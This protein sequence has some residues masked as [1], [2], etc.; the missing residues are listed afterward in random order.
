MQNKSELCNTVY[1]SHAE[2]LL[3]PFINNKMFD[4]SDLFILINRKTMTEMPDTAMSL[5]IFKFFIELG[6]L[7]NDPRDPFTLSANIESV[8]LILN[9]DDD[10]VTG[11]DYYTFI[12]NNFDTYTLLLKKWNELREYKQYKPFRWEI[13][14]TVD[15]FNTFSPEIKLMCVFEYDDEDE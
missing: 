12:Y 14:E 6:Y 5:L 2:T 1:I 9:R 7:D 4:L 15:V 11:F 10:D 13:I 3:N 8:A